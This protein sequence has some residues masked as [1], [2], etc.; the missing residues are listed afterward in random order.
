MPAGRVV[1][2]QVMKLFGLRGEVLIAPT[3]DDP[4]RFEPGAVVFLAEDRERD[5][6]DAS[7]TVAQVRPHQAAWLVTFEGRPDR[8]SVE[9][10]ARRL[11][12][13]DAEDLPAL[14][15][16]EF[17]HYQLV[18]LRVTRPDGSTLGRITQV[19]DLPGSDLYEVR[20]P[21]GTWLVPAR[22]EFVAW[23]NLEKHE[24][25]LTDRT[26]LLEAQADRA[27]GE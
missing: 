17:Y 20:G 5:G 2:G 9:D 14:P 24:L 3:G 6:P 12:Y 26:D 27:A 13:Q 23:I 1:V 11:L 8:T 10:L 19:I 7:L 18:D 21:G 25:R 22:S 4:R 15:E 16:G